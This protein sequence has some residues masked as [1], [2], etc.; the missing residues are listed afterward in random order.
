[1]LGLVNLVLGG[2][3]AGAGIEC[4]VESGK[5]SNFTYTINIGQSAADCLLMNNPNC[6]LCLSRRL[7]VSSRNDPP[8]SPR[9]WRLMPFLFQIMHRDTCRKD[10]PRKW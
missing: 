9:Q 7:L 3:V 4:A 1:M 8:C 2:V 10:I 5:A 6:G